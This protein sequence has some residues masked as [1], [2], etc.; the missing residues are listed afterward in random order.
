MQEGFFLNDKM[1][2][3]WLYWYENGQKKL[4]ANYIDDLQVGK[5]ITWTEDGKE[6]REKLQD[7]E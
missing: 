4:E 5:W 6:K 1:N 2:G 3:K 7:E